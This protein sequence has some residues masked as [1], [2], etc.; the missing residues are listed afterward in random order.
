MV[1]ML[2]LVFVEFGRLE[3]WGLL[4]VTSGGFASL[5]VTV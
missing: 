3:D 5:H 4:N 1:K 2:L